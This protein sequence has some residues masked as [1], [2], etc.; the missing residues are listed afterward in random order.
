MLYVSG[1]TK[2]IS[3]SLYTDISVLF[4]NGQHNHIQFLIV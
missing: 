4:L 2:D 3:E 1:L